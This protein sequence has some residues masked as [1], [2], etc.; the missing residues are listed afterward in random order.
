MTESYISA[1]ADFLNADGLEPATVIMDRAG[2]SRVEVLVDKTLR[3]SLGTR[4]MNRS[5]VSVTSG[6]RVWHM[7]RSDLGDGMELETGDLII[8]SSG[9]QWKA[10][11]VD[12]ICFGT[13][14]RA[15]CNKLRR[16][17]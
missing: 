11:S 13:R 10:E 3:M 6:T 17:E 2:K 7:R 15:I 16:N 9:V 1:D 14:I 12:L 8:D 5:D 4:D